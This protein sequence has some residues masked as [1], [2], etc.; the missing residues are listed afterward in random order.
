VSKKICIIGFSLVSCGLQAVFAQYAVSGKVLN[1]SGGSPVEFA[2][3]MLA[4]KGLWTTTDS[5]GEFVLRKVPAGETNVTLSCLGYAETTVRLNVAGDVSIVWY[6]R[7][8][9]LQLDEVV[10]TAK[11]QSDEIATSYV[12]DRAG[13]EHMQMMN[14]TDAMSLLPGGQTTRTE[15]FATDARRIALRAATTLES[16]NPT[17]GTAVEVDG[18]RLSTNGDYSSGSIYGTDVRN[19]AS[20]N[21]ESIAVT[22][23]VPS[24]EYGDL[25]G[26]MVR[27]TT[28][29]GK[30]PLQVE[31]ITQPNTKLISIGKG[32]SL[33]EKAGI[34]NISAEHAKSIV[35]LASP[36]TSYARN[37]L[38]LTYSNTVNGRHD[39]SLGIETGVTGNTGGYD[40]KSDPDA[41]RDTWSKTK[42][43]TLRAH[44]R[45]NW[46]LRR[47]WLNSLEASGNA[48]YSDKQ[49][50]IR[51]NKSS[52]A[53]VVA[54]HGK[55]EGYFVAQNYDESPDAPIVLIPAGYWYQMQHFDNRPLNIS[56]SVKARW[57]YRI[58]TTDNKLLLGADFSSASNKGRGEYYGDLR[59]APT[60]REYRY[61]R[62][63]FTRNVALY[64]EEKLAVPAGK[65]SSFQATA[66]VRADVTSVRNSVYGTVRSLSPRFNA[67]YVF[68]N[69][70]DHTVESF[71]LRAGW[72]KAV[73]LPSL[74]VL[75]PQPRYTDK[76]AFVPGTMADG[77]SFYGYYIDP[78]TIPYNPALRW[79]HSR[80]G[81]IGGEMQIGSVK[82]SL[83]L[84]R[85]K[86]V[87]SYT[88]ATDYEPF[89]Y[90]LTDQSA[91]EQSAI[92]STDRTYRIDQTTG[93][94]TVIDK[95]GQRPNETLAYTNRNM[96]RA[97]TTYINGSPALRKGVEWTVDFGKIRALQTSLR[98]DGNYYH[99]RS[100]EE[101]VSAYWPSN[102]FMSDGTTPYQYV[103][104][105]TGGNSIGNGSET[106]QVNTNITIVTHIPAI[107]LIVSLRTEVVL[108]RTARNL[109]EYP[110]QPAFALESSEAHFPAA[111]NP[112][113]I[114]NSDRII[115]A[116]PLYYVTY[117]DMNTKIPFAEKFRWAK[118]NDPALFNELAR[119]IL[120]SNTDYYFN[121]NRISAYC[122]ANINVTKEIGNFASLSFHAA[123]FTNNLRQ[124]KTSA[125]NQRQSLFRSSYIP[126]FYYGLSLKIKV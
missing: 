102:F 111:D 61:D 1:K 123:N 67:R 28:K 100:V 75:H 42:D 57:V 55:D 33:G 117:D 108:Y 84:F 90:K 39:R 83:S 18:V 4:E 65:K 103:A 2:R 99:Y 125:A 120:R 76:V 82:L 104:Y 43:N 8:D 50:T 45:L 91:L 20:G 86:T 73:K 48:S 6:L 58:G 3:V 25:T 37:T 44:L 22:T 114:Y 9:N 126:Y 7:E 54:L 77:T 26:G 78:Y 56:T 34:L 5:K 35:S 105:Y 95:T 52:S 64:A 106:R 38:T 12:I 24:V 118:D 36:Y 96:F 59:Y 72:G 27:I 98:I 11:R 107:R 101:T 97:N 53:S 66:G 115:A 41:F 46:L 85:H 60:W 49:Q 15:H 68:K 51:T 13:L 31:A 121:D 119:L 88:T 40:S 19:V 124:V 17:F 32:L 21:V 63:P 116:Y 79:Q 10:I 89:S 81:E 110:E 112:D 71:S 29:K 70:K 14:V 74:G 87:N 23:G 92:P 69:G 30:T 93:V 62:I 109:C 47:P 80:Q 16:G 94:V 113:Q 122:S